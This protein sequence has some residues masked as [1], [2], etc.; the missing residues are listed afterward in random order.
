MNCWPMRLKEYSESGFAIDAG[1]S[2]CYN[3]QSLLSVI[4]ESRKGNDAEIQ[5][6]F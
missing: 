5:E 1:I 6:L 2:R 4:C 3:F